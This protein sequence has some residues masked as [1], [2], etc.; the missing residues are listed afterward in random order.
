MKPLNMAEQSLPTDFYIDPDDAEFYLWGVFG[1]SHKACGEAELDGE[2][3]H[4][5]ESK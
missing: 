1:K 3:G 4:I 2:F 5:F